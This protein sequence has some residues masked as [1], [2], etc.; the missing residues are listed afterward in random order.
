MKIYV[1]YVNG[2]EVERIERSSLAQAGQ[3]ARTKY[4]GRGI[5]VV[6][7]ET[8]AGTGRDHGRIF[9]TLS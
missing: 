8:D 5:R 1:V 7:S 2:S 4:R 3:Y 6:E 9:G